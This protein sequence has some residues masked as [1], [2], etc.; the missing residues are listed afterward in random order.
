M[1]RFIL[2]RHGATSMNDPS[3]EKLRG[4]ADVPLS[5]EGIKQSE[6]VAE[7]LKLHSIFAISTSDLKRANDVADKIN[8]HHDLKIDI[9]DSLRPWHISSKLE[10]KPIEEVIPHMIR[11]IND[12][13]NT[14]D[15]GESFLDFQ[16][17]S[18]SKIQELMN[19]CMLNPDKT[20]IAV[21][22]SRN[23]RLL[24][25][26]ILAGAQ[27]I[28]VIDKAPMLQKE[29]VIGPGEYLEAE[30]INNEWMLMDSVHYASILKIDTKLYNWLI[31]LKKETTTD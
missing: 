1:P 17:R 23:A 14:M 19:T 21:A 6:K 8:E 25:S 30:F 3:N 26:W 27:D 2:V 29:D 13:N 7:Q 15:D 12:E 16:L 31:S 10:G 4:H 28:H 24:K 18:L 22:H 11:L 9:S 5:E 20:I